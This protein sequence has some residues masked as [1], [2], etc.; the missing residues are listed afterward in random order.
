MNEYTSV[1]DKFARYSIFMN[2]LFATSLARGRISIGEKCAR[3]GIVFCV[4][5]KKNEEEVEAFLSNAMR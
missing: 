1:L 3:G 5:Q 2:L 4:R